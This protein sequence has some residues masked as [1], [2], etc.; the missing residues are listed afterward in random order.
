MTITPNGKYIICAEQ[1]TVFIWDSVIRKCLVK[2]AQPAVYQII[3]KEE[4]A[5]AIFISRSD[6]DKGLNGLCRSV[7]LP[8]GEKVYEFMFLMR[9]QKKACLTSKGH[10]LVISSI[11]KMEQVLQIY[12]ANT[13]TF[14]HQFVPKHVS[15]SD[16]CGVV[17]IDSHPTRV[18]L[19]GTSSGFIFDIQNDSTITPHFVQAI[20]SWTGI[21]NKDGKL[22][23]IATQNG[24]LQVI[25][26]STNKIKH[27]LIN[28]DLKQFDVIAMFSENDKYVIHYC[29]GRRTIRL[30]TV[31]DG[32]KV[33]EFYSPTTVNVIRCGHQGNSLIIGLADGRVIS[34][35]I[36]DRKGHLDLKTEHDNKEEVILQDNS[37]TDI[38]MSSAEKTDLLKLVNSVSSRRMTKNKFTYG[39]GK[40]R[41]KAVAKLTIKPRSDEKNSKMCV[42]M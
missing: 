37:K 32:R 21:Q 34:L 7:T 19:I 42:V 31:S 39:R 26:L 35:G 13:G 40:S 27:T 24:L 3:L 9:A 8:L 11:D 5:S 14:L 15:L 38:K 22:G 16:F 20:T 6:I 29:T 18:A 1:K 41:F 25:E 33:A 28:P 2:F 36:I 17:S 10:Y 23:I 4:G 30:Y 12:H